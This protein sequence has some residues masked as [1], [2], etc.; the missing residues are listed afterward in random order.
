MNECVVRLFGAE[1]LLGQM[2]FTPDCSELRL[3]VSGCVCGI[4]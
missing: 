1:L 4:I 2:I 3:C